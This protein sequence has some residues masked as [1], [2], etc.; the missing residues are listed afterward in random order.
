MLT[1]KASIFFFSSSLSI[2][3]FSFYLS[4]FFNVLSSLP[5]PGFLTLH[6]IFSYL[7]TY[8]YHYYYH[9]LI[10]TL[11]LFIHPLSFLLSYFS[12]FFSVLSS[13]PYPGF[14]TL[15]LAFFFPYLLTYHHHYHHLL[16]YILNLFI[17]HLSIN[18]RYDLF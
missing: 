8:S 3:F 5:Y 12:F 9:L 13:L 18:N 4:F 7:L 17:H 15:R 2:L 14:L 10:Y 6:L 1:S 11:N 16:I